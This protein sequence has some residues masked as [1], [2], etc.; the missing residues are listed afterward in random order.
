MHNT[1]HQDG[2]KYDPIDSYNHINRKR[3]HISLY[4]LHHYRIIRNHHPISEHV[5]PNI[6]EAIGNTPLVQLQRIPSSNGLKC[7]I[8]NL[9]ITLFLITLLYSGKM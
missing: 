5:L 6:L 8:C 7:R 9:F 1:Q 2:W 3:Y 4:L